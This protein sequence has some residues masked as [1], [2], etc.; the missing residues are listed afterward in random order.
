MLISTTPS[1]EGK[2]IKEYRGVVFG[3][4]IN[5]INFMKDFTANIANFI[6]GRAKEYEQELVDARAQAL[7]EMTERAGRIGANAVVG[8]KVDIETIGQNGSMIMV[9]ASGTAVVTD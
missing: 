4:A 5:G 2:T 9:V 6:G 1:L 3:E 7:S 8:V